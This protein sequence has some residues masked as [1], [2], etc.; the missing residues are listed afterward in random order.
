MRDCIDFLAHVV[1]DADSGQRGFHPRGG[2]PRPHPGHAIA[3][4]RPTAFPLDRRGRESCAWLWALF[5]T[6]EP[7]FAQAWIEVLLLLA[8]FLP[9][10]GAA[11]EG[12]SNQA[13]F[14]RISKRSAAMASGFAKYAAKIAPIKAGPP[15][16]LADVI[17]MSSA[18]AEAMVA[19][20]VDW[21]AVFIDRPQ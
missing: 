17:P 20:V 8:A 13:E 3:Q 12:I 4:R 10:L 21:R 7:S 15:P 16:K 11:L 18:I 2:G 6:L 5:H 1:G 14:L 9:A 19:E